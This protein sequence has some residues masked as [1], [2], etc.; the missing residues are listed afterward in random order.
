MSSVDDL[1][2]VACLS[3]LASFDQD[4]VDYHRRI[5]AQFTVTGLAL[6]DYV[7]DPGFGGASG[8]AATGWASWLKQSVQDVEH[9]LV[10]WWESEAAARAAMR[11][12]ASH[13]GEVEAIMLQAGS[14]ALTKGGM[15]AALALAAQAEALAAQYLATMNT[16]VNAAVNAADLGGGTIGSDPSGGGTDYEPGW[17]TGGTSS[18]SGSGGSGSGSG[19]GLPP[20]RVPPPPVPPAPIPPTPPHPAPPPPPPP[21]PPDRIP[22]RGYDPPNGPGGMV[23]PG[24]AAVAAAIALGSGGVGSLAGFRG[25]SGV[26]PP[27]GVVTPTGW[28]TRIGA[29]PTTPLQT[30]TTSG[31][32]SSGM[33]MAPPMGGAGGG[34]TGSKRKRGGYRVQHLDNPTDAPPD[35]G[36]G[37]QAGTVETMPPAPEPVEDDW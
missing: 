11:E 30:P 26:V 6:Q 27:G 10:T 16:A 4:E 1:R 14:M 7:A 34:Q 8:D 19:G 5:S 25:L 13:L 23:L 36:W 15:D 3:G 32:T 18:G 35:P 24:A 28:G 20:G 29:T 37:A 9:D 31:Q 33:G 22:G 17:D 21:D 2:D 12:A